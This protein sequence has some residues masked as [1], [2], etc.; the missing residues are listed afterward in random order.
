MDKTNFVRV[1]TVLFTILGVAHL[2]RAI[3]NL[4]VEIGGWYVPVPLSW[5][6]AGILAV[7][8]FIGY[9]NW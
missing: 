5:I 7:L 1:A 2:V 3:L 8:S 9:L 4:P 6:A